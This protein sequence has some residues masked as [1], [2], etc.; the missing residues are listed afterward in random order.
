MIKRF[1]GLFAWVVFCGIIQPALAGPYSAV[2]NDPGNIYDAPVP[3]FVGPHGIGKARILTGVDD[4]GDPVFQN[5]DNMVNPLFFGWATQ[6]TDYYRADAGSA[7][8]D[9][10]LALGEVTG[11][12]FDIVSL[13]DLSAAQ[14]T[15]GSLPG[16]I[17]LQLALPI[18]N[19]SGADFVVFENG[20]VS[21]SNQGGA[22]AGGLLAELAYVEVSAN[23]TDFIR[24]PATS[25]TPSAVG[26]Y[27]SLNPTNIYNLAGKH[28]NAYGNSWGTPFDLAQVGLQEITHVRLVDIPGNGAFHDQAGR[29]IYD[30]WL[31]FGSGGFDL[32]AVGGISTLMTFAAWP[33]LQKLAP[34]QRGEAD[35]P[36]GD[37]LP[38]LLE[39]AFARVPWLA[40]SAGATPECRTIAAAGNIYPQL[41]FIR[42]ERLTDLTYEVQVSENM[43][44]G[45]WTT[46]A[47]STAGNPTQAV[48]GNFP[49]VTESAASPL[50]GIGVIRAVSVRDA[51]P[52]SANARRLFRVKISHP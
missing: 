47:S 22:G 16:S 51:Q 27:G 32:E 25:L 35:D 3:G 43:A 31:T 17:T 20:L 49:V 9:P 6:A 50:T 44:T 24:F 37:G 48:A 34:G 7:F 40:D 29:S 23:G 8:S 14:I 38:N 5:P 52:V 28:T 4:M 26:A 19:L 1:I 39:Y 12:N 11:D 33:A 42:D 15:A 2:M 18:R 45:S 13:G 36:D 10:A 21:Q 41:S 30:A 46:I